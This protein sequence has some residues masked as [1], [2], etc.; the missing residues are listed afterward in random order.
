[1]AKKYKQETYTGSF[2]GYAQGMGFN[3]VRQIN[4]SKQYEQRAKEQDRVLQTQAQHQQRTYQV[5][6]AQ[7]NANR[8]K[9]N[10]NFAALKGL[11]SIIGQSSSAIVKYTK[12]QE[13]RQA[14]EERDAQ[15]ALEID[16]QLSSWAD[17]GVEL[18]A[19]GTEGQEGIQ[20][21][22]EGDEQITSQ[23]EAEGAA[24]NQVAEEVD[25]PGIQNELRQSASQVRY[26]GEVGNV[27]SARAGHYNYLAAKAREIP[28]AQKP[29]TE[30]EA[31]QLIR[32]WNAQ[33]IRESGILKNPAMR[34]MVA[35][36]MTNTV[37]QNNA[38][39]AKGMV[40]GVVQF[41]QKNNA[42]EL[43]NTV[44]QAVNGGTAAADI[45]RQTSDATAFGNMG[46][47]G[48]SRASNEAAIKEIIKQAVAA[49]NPE[50]LIDLLDTP[51]IPGQPNGPTL[52]DEF[53]AT[54]QAG[55]EQA[56]ASRRTEFDNQTAEMNL[57]MK[58]DLREY[59]LN[60]T[61]EARAQLVERLRALP[62]PEA[63]RQLRNLM[64]EGLGVDID[65][66]L[67]L[68]QRAARGEEI[69][70]WELEEALR[71]GRIRQEVYTQRMKG[72]DEVAT[73]EASKKAVQNTY[74]TIV[75]MMKSTIPQ[76]MPVTP[77]MT[78]EIQRRAR[79]FQTEL[80]RRV[81]LETRNN[82]GLRAN[83]ME[84][85]KIV[86]AQMA[87]MMKQPQYQLEANV[88]TGVT[89]KGDMYDTNFDSRAKKYNITVAPGEQD[90]RTLTPSD[91]LNNT[92]VPKSELS[93][94]DDYL[95][96][97]E[98]LQEAVEAYS[99][100]ND[101]GARVTNLAK[102]MGLSPKAFMEG[103]L[104]RYQL[105]SIQAFEQS[106]ATPVDETTDFNL[107]TGYNYIQRQLG[108]PARGAAYL[109][110]AID[111]E[112]AWNGKREWGQVAGDGTNRNG[113][114]I[115]WASWANNSARLGAIERY[116]GRPIS[117]ISEMAQLNYMKMEMQRSYRSA[118]NVFMDPNASSADLQWAVSRYWGFDPKYTGSRWTDAERYITTPPR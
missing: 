50:V 91:I 82:P 116:Y 59:F 113:G 114:L 98:A 14:Q 93:A 51:K 96:S 54:I 47:N 33:Y 84:M 60:P 52:R 95:I 30:A 18:T 44:F 34:K 58:Q 71:S 12:E 90:F 69:P 77:A 112:S 3:P 46:F 17:M 108:F 5:Q 99:S 61:P 111:H 49:K 87:E 2:Q 65:Y 103:Q 28:D 89:W 64:G 110:S 74:Q 36:E 85:A 104:K 55:I 11:A 100:G 22:I 20:S 94:E 57:M 9:S 40:A 1:M 86:D 63:Q 66:E 67:E 92:V 76:N 117:Q 107:A 72:N 15:E 78:A 42:S 25:S 48:R 26:S 118:Y 37:L 29:R 73:D 39:I 80:A 88:K 68:A 38:A 115:S 45:W 19:G 70:K 97:Q 56:Q 106:A 41:D 13:A 4:K 35:K 7:L 8:A 79:I 16:Q 105:P 53:G 75:G 6:S 24:I 10:A 21:V 83:D 43:G 102:G 32:Q 101:P 23:K 27:Y 109:T 81:S 62:T 31:A